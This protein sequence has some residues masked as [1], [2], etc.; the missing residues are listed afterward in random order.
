M[1]DHAAALA[2]IGPFEGR[3][4]WM[5][6]DTT[7]HVTCGVGNML[8]N[9]DAA[10]ALIWH[11]RGSGEEASSIDI[12][13]DYRR[14]SGAVPGMAAAAYKALTRCELASHEIERLFGRRVDE[15]ALQLEK[16]FHGFPTF[17]QP[18]QLAMLDMAFNLGA[19]ALPRK[20]PMLTKAINAENWPAAAFHCLRPQSRDSRNAA[21]RALFEAAANEG[22]EIA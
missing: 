14:V 21:V 6:L 12:E 8:P 19:A 22:R 1:V 7:S 13:D 17:P 15:F 18:A 3:I 5:Y 11:V 2:L 9:V 20:F 16:I 4:P 10:Q